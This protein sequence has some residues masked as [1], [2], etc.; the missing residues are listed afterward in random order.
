MVALPNRADILRRVEHSAIA[1]LR[2]ALKSR[3]GVPISWHSSLGVLLGMVVAAGLGQLLDLI[4]GGKTVPVSIIAGMFL[5]LLAV[6]GPFFMSLRLVLAVG[7][8][9]TL[10]SGLA[11]IAG[12]HAWLAVAGMVVLVFVGSVWTAIPL[13][14]SLIGN[15]PII[16]F[17]LILVKGQTFTGG[18]AAGRVMLATAAGVV[19]ALIVLAIFSGRDPRKPTRGLVAKA[20]GPLATSRQQG[21]MLAVLRL[22]SAP[23]ALITVGQA[24][25]LAMIARGRLE[26]E[27]ETDAYTA[28]LKAQGAIAAALMPRGRIVGRTVSPPVDDARAKIRRA[29]KDAAQPQVS[30]AWNRWQVALEYGAGVLEGKVPPRSAVFSSGSLTRALVSSV[31]HV[32]SAGF[33]YGVQRAAALGVATFVMLSTSAPN[34]Y[35]I[36]LTIF[37]V[38]Q[39]NAIAT[40]SKAAQYALGT[41]TGAVGALALSLLLPRGVV[42]IVALGLI[43]AG[44]AWMARNYMVMSVAVAAAV[45]LVSG[46]PDGEFLKW[47]GLRAL[48]VGC[49]ALIAIAVSALVLRVR[50]EPARHIEEARNALLATVGRLRSRFQDPRY[51]PEQSVFDESRFL[52]AISNMQ[53]DGQLLRD[54]R[55][56]SAAAD[57]LWDL[58]EQALAL[59]SVIFQEGADQ[60]DLGPPGSRDLRELVDRALTDLEREIE[61]VALAPAASA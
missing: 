30:Y 61:Q 21:S 12:Q 26:S 18:A 13:V 60:G 23:R 49:G 2:A 41:W 54:S 58:N 59:A 51:R 50:P 56:V 34:F 36:L 25:I 37:S 38:L 22:D 31:L 19:A 29:G 6:M 9:M 16:V 28:G 40:V 11:V 48:D 35:W 17:L 55:P 7:V 52:R 46:A 8:L 15:F 3:P 45:V 44:F 4:D 53:A 33:R 1:R 14:G 27:K 57:R 24:A 10:T 5:G 42:A 32:D 43:I 20:W 39:A 47:A